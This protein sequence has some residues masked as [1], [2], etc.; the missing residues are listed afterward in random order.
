MRKKGYA[1][2]IMYYILI[3]WMNIFGA[4]YGHLIDLLVFIL[5]I[6]L[7]SCHNI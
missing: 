2:I 3:Y 7:L 1:F 6:F 4:N 5:F